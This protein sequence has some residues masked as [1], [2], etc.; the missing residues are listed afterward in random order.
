[1]SPADDNIENALHDKTGLT[2]D[3]RIELIRPLPPPD[4][5]MREFPIRGSSSSSV[6]ARSTIRTLRS[7]TRTS[8]AWSESVMPIRSKS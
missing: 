3:E 8:F 1:M 5:L 4:D 2:D 7:N 6:L